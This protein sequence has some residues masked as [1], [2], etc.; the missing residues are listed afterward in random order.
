MLINFQWGIVSSLYEYSRPAVPDSWILWKLFGYR[1]ES[2]QNFYPTRT[3]TVRNFIFLMRGN[4]KR[5]RF[6]G[7][8][9]C[10]DFRHTHCGISRFFLHLCVASSKMNFRWI[11]R[12]MRSCFLSS[13]RSLICET[14]FSKRFT[15]FEIVVLVNLFMNLNIYQLVIFLTNFLKENT[16]RRVYGGVNGEAPQ[17]FCKVRRRRRCVMRL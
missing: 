13:L 5:N 15:A 10:A 7:R 17:R 11:F 2:K 16:S 14:I 3:F 8:T 1:I 4:L 12:Q 9:K 6:L